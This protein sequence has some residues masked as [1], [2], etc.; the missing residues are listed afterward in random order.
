MRDDT[1]DPVL[2]FRA[3]ADADGE[4]DLHLAGRILLAAD[5]R[6]PAAAEEPAAEERVPAQS[7]DPQLAPPSLDDAKPDDALPEPPAAAF[8]GE[9]DPPAW[10][11]PWAIPAGEHVDPAQILRD[12]PDVYAAFYREYFGPNNDRNSD[13]WIDRVGGATPEDYA[14]YWYKTYG[15]WQGYTPGAPSAQGAPLEGA[16]AVVAGRTTFDGVPLAKIL[17][18]RPDVFQAFF[19]EYYGAGN[20]RHS[21]AWVQR[22]GGNT[23][24]DYAD[25]WYNAHGKLA[26]Y[27]PSAPP[28]AA[29]QA[30]PADDDVPPAPE[31]DAPSAVEG[32][33]GEPAPGEPA[34]DPFVYSD[35][36]A[37]ML[38]IVAGRSLFDDADPFG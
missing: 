35:P 18:D 24:E 37:P 23:P 6:T 28:P 16:E 32:P 1:L 14:R 33:A 31:V 30:P 15:A 5:T 11:S 4:L 17:A 2:D 3:L 22:V 13:A 34:P 26:G 25:Y 36:A 29:G 12:R 10:T 21:D 20:D 19:T 27:V 7:A 38:P 9:D 8:A